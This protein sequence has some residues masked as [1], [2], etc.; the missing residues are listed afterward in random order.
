MWWCFTELLNSQS[1]V[2]P[3]FRLMKR[4]DYKKSVSNTNSH[5]EFWSTS[6]FH[7]DCIK[8]T[9]TVEINISEIGIASILSISK[10][11]WS[12]YPCFFLH[13]FRVSLILSDPWFFQGLLSPAHVVQSYYVIWLSAFLFSNCGKYLLFLTDVSD[14]KSLPRNVTVRGFLQGPSRVPEFEVGER[15]DKGVRGFHKQGG[16]KWAASVIY[17]SR[18]SHLWRAVPRSQNPALGSRSW[19]N[20]FSC[21]RLWSSRAGGCPGP[22]NLRVPQL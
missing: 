16:E 7:S 14:F 22:R 3:L 11:W 8:Y 21:S 6:N 10:N 17:A 15:K 19:K 20:R 18:E 9:S 5:W 2:A 1:P 4:L 13:K 12:L